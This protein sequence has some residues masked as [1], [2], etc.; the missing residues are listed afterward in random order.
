MSDPDEGRDVR[1]AF[2]TLL[3]DEP[4][5]LSRGRRPTT[6][7]R[8]RAL[9]RRRR[10]R[11]GA[12]IGLVA[13]VVMVFGVFGTVAPEARGRRATG[14]AVGRA[15]AAGDRHP[16]RPR[17][18]DGRRGTG[19]A[20]S[21]GRLGSPR[22][23]GAHP[24]A[25]RRRRRSVKGNLVLR[26]C[27]TRRRPSEDRF[28]A[29]GRPARPADL[30][31]RV[32]GDAPTCVPELLVSSL[33]DSCGPGRGRARWTETSAPSCRSRTMSTAAARGVSCWYRSRRG[34]QQAIASTPAVTRPGVARSARRPPRR[35]PAVG[36]PRQPSRRGRDGRL[37]I[38]VRRCSSG[39]PPPAGHA[40]VA[41][42]ESADH[43]RA[44]RR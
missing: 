26:T 30:A 25:R 42:H 1:A 32:A 40:A 29:A 14:F 21:R 41:L 34:R 44:S 3:A 16:R 37:P 10:T 8:G 39:W 38:K 27:G 13:A 20:P 43:R 23:D 35:A 15:R 7:P 28:G 22:L 33:G 4:T 2:G 31:C 24:G 9:Q 12:G 5:D 11:A 19:A 17:V 6:S 18:G 36:A